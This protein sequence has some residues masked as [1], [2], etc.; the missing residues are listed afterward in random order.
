MKKILSYLLMGSLF[1]GCYNTKK[2]ERSY[3]LFQTGLDSLAN[4]SFKE[5]RIKEGDNL[6]IQVYTLASINQEQV[7]LFNLQGKANN[8]YVV[9]NLGQIELPTIGRITVMG[10]T[11]TQ[12]K[13][14]LKTEWGKY[15][16][17]IV[18]DVQLSGFTVNI[19]GEVKTPGV[20]TFKSEKAT[21]IDV[22]AAAGGLADEGKRE[23]VLIIREDSGKR[24]SYY[25]DLRDA[26]FYN[27]PAFQLQQND[28]VYVSAGPTKFNTIRS[29]T[30]QQNIM[31]VTSIATLASFAL[32]IVV[33]FVALNRN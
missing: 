28:M 2:I 11:C 23:N 5:L 4:I 10:Q 12:I 19:L 16:K 29:N 9:N 18:V 17:D 1:V 21:L 8:G 27:S 7:S 26:K 14:K 32:N 31:P 6:Q 22:I 25:V 13:E 24:T 15:V 20:K 3:Q 33:V 30:F